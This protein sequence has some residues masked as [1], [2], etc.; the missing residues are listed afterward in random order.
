MIFK[1]GP[2]IRLNLKKIHLKNHSIQKM[3]NSLYG[4]RFALP[5]RSHLATPLAHP[6]LLN[7]NMVGDLSN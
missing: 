3:F 1:L 4:S 6:G 7:Y 2:K 5:Q